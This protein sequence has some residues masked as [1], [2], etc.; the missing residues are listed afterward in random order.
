M[1]SAMKRGL[2]DAE[3]CGRRRDSG[4]RP[5]EV[6]PV[7]RAQR[8]GA[9]RACGDEHVD[10]LYGQLSQ[11]A[12]K[13]RVVPSVAGEHLIGAAQRLAVVRRARRRI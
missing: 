7:D 2:T 12:G 13:D 9:C 3:R 4:R 11:V 5:V 1:I 6:A 8:G 10:R